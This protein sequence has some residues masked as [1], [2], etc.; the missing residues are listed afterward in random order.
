MSLHKACL[1]ASM[2]AKTCMYSQC[3][4]TEI[5]VAVQQQ[6]IP[7]LQGP[8]PGQCDTGGPPCLPRVV[9]HHLSLPELCLFATCPISGYLYKMRRLCK[10]YLGD[11]L[12][13]DQQGV[14]PLA[15]YACQE[16]ADLATC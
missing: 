8:S 7:E 13:H 11:V 9:Q 12:Q 4:G 2:L 10:T 3:Q 14:H 1:Y 15:A 16:N 5:K 6:S